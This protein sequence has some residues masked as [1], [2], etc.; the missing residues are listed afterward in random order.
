MGIRDVLG[1]VPTGTEGPITLY[2]KA[3]FAD[4]IKLKILR[5]GDYPGL[6]GWA[7]NIITSVPIKET[8]GENI[9][10]KRRQ[11][12]DGGKDWKIM[13]T[14]QGLLVAPRSWKR[15]ETIHPGVSGGSMT[16]Q[17]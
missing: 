10:R 3:V 5:W 16:H 14:G 12:D 9:Q 17:H 2:G 4:V 13:A 11:E 8:E 15:Q 1:P 7:L 6:S